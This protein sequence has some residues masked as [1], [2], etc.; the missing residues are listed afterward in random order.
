MLRRKQGLTRNRVTYKGRLTNFGNCA[1][2]VVNKL[3]EVWLW[4]CGRWEKCAS[5]CMEG[6]KIVICGCKEDEN[7]VCGC[8]EGKKVWLW[9]Q[10][11]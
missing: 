4:L 8:E 1:E 2:V 5:G 11:R 6:E 3:L 9:L 7:S 10:G